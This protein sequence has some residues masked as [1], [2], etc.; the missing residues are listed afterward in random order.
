MYNDFCKFQVV[1]DLHQYSKGQRFHVQPSRKVGC[2]AQ[3]VVRHVSVFTDRQ[4]WAQDIPVRSQK[5]QNILQDILNRI[6]NESPQYTGEE[7]IY[8]CLPLCAAHSKHTVN[9]K[10]GLGNRINDGVKCKIYETVNM[11]ITNI[12]VVKKILKT[13]VETEFENQDVKPSIFD[14]AYYPLSKDIKNHI[15][16]AIASGK[17][18]SLDQ[19]NLK[20]KI[21]AWKLEDLDRLFYYRPATERL[22]NTDGEKFLFLHQENWQRRLLKMYGNTVSLLDATYRTTK[23]NLPFFMLVV[24]TNVEYIPVAQFVT[25]DETSESIQEALQILKNWNPDWCPAYFM[26]DYSEA[27]INSIKAEFE[28]TKIL[29]CAFHREQAWERWSRSGNT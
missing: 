26:V 13:Y 4:Y 7:K 23:Y 1:P 11:G 27:E 8:I 24:R 10:I 6:Q 3:I 22:E 16:T 9:P 19:E 29:L 2:G 18:G 15:H 5:R 28:S 25:E 14:R 21:E 12:N 17:L 20:K